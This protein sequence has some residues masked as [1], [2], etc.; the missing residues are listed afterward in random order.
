MS[1]CRRTCRPRLCL[2]E[3][4]DVDAV[5]GEVCRVEPGQIENLADST[6]NAGQSEVA[7]LPH[8]VAVAAS[9]VIPPSSAVLRRTVPAGIAV[10]VAVV[11]GEGYVLLVTGK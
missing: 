11:G 10:V 8:Q 7:E 2:S 9:L 5:G 4:E 6:G 3:E 1:I